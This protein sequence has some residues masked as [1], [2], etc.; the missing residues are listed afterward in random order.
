MGEMSSL[1]AD[2]F[3]GLT[4]NG[5]KRTIFVIILLFFFGNPNLMFDKH[6]LFILIAILGYMLG[7][8]L[9]DC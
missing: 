8:K 1:L 4:P 9:M 7:S 5:S 3:V 6:V 2:N